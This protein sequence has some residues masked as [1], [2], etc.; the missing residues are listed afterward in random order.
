M[1]LR[2][3]VVIFMMLGFGTVA[4]AQDSLVD[5]A[6]AQK[7]KDQ[8]KRAT[9]VYTNE[10]LPTGNINVVGT[11]AVDD[12]KASDGAKPAKDG[13]EEPKQ[14]V[15][16]DRAAIEAE[17]KQR[18]DTA[19]KEVA[20]LEHELDENRRQNRLRIASY[21]GMPDDIAAKFIEADYEDFLKKRGALEEA[22]DKLEKLVK[23]ARSAGM[24]RAVL[25]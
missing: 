5:A 15:K 25:E 12:R 6:R 19:R 13:K 7:N 1:D 18:L 24:P 8:D 21:A 10:N 14:D 9:K 16:K 4:L 11:F 2:P 22:E 17:W 23:Q 20:R 3:F